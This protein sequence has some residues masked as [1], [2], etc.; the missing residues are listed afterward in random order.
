ML[1]EIP[2]RLE[3]TYPI[4][5]IERPTANVAVHGHG[6]EFKGSGSCAVRFDRVMSGFIGLTVRGKAGSVL[7]IQP[8]EPDAPGFHRMATVRLRDGEQQLELP[9]YDSFSVIN[10]VAD[11]PM[12]ILDVR[13]NFVAQPVQY[14]GSFACSDPKLNRIWEVSRWLTQICQQTHHLDSP[15]H[16]EPISDPGDYLIISLNNYCAFGQPAL[17]RQDLRKYGWLLQTT[18]YR[19]F[20]TSYALLW[21]QMLMNYEAYTGDTALVRELAPTVEALLAQFATYIGKNGIVSE[22]PDYMF[23]DWVTIAGF[24]THHPP[25]VIGQGYMTA[26]LYHAL[27]DGVRVAQLAGDPA[28]ASEYERMRQQIYAAYNRELWD[29]SA[30]LYR[31]GKPFVTSV[32][33]AQWL[34][35]DTD[36]ETHST[37]NN[38]LAVLYDLAPPERRAPIM[39]KLLGGDLN[40]QPYFM[41][42]VFGALAHA[43]LFDEFGTAQMRRWTIEP[44]TQSFREMWG[45]GDYSH[46]WQ[47]TPLY[48]MSARVL[49]VS[50]LSP[51]FARFR[52][53]PHCCDLDWA[54]GEIPTPHG[55]ISVSWKRSSQTFEL[56]VSVP[57]GTTA[58]LDLP[59]GFSSGSVEVDGTTARAEEGSIDLLPGKHMV[60]ALAHS[61]KS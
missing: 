60:R 61:P 13:A 17:A 4:Q 34:P 49:G 14:A 26:F 40:T 1:S 58:R 27:A 45:N 21:L 29:P 54:H 43:G 53:A 35:A 36:I 28:K 11:G 48:Q 12:E 32:K 19:P 30:G 44:D 59:S 23:M 9:F 8:N 31:D 24:Q 20:H 52:I 41:H 25:A 55:P 42:F 15:H 5:K 38:S 47:C 57:S 18:H 37:Q 3:A 16:Q 39:R 7:A 10:L 50:P 6:L 33:P 51:G 46:A 56:E 22:A 2:A